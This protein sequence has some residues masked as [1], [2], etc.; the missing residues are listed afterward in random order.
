MTPGRWQKIASIYELVVERDAVERDAF[1][2]D[3]CAGDDALRREVESLLRQDAA[4]V[5][6]DQSVWATVAPLFVGHLDLRAGASL[7]PYRI[8]RL[9]GAG[10]MGEVFSATDTR[11]NRRVAIKVLPAGVAPDEE[12]RARF[13]REAKAVAALT[14]PHI[15]TLYDVG[16][17]DQIDFLVMEYLEGD[18]LATR[19]AKGRLPFEEAITKAIEIAERARPRAPPRHRASRSEARPTSS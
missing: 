12:M 8:D 10:G 18:T 7:G 1:L 15:C 17:Q 19:L 6:L 2:A 3:A 5:V 13:A 16:S 9:L 4:N 14:H 11:L